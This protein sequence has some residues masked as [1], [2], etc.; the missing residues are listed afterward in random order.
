MCSCA[1]QVGAES[2]LLP[3]LLLSCL[4]WPNPL[5]RIKKWSRQKGTGGNVSRL[6]HCWIN[7]REGRE[8]E[9][10]PVRR[11]YSRL[12]FKVQRKSTTVPK[13]VPKGQYGKAFIAPGNGCFWL[14]E[15]RGGDRQVWSYSYNWRLHVALNYVF[16][17]HGH[18]CANPW[19]LQ[20]DLWTAWAMRHTAVW[21]TS[22]TL[23]SVSTATLCCS[24]L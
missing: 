16:L 9:L 14:R 4:E 10:R 7:T 19:P 17:L 6:G 24:S 8:V 5:G 18:D 11:I 15:P 23:L 21:A 22:L 1:L 12:G 13:A 3:L 20:W 2:Q